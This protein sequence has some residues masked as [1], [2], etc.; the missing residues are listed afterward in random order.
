MRPEFIEIQNVGALPL[1]IG[2]YTFEGLTYTFPANTVI[3]PGAALLLA[4]SANPT[5]FAARYPGV[6][7]FG[8][9]GGNLSNGGE[10]VAILDLSGAIVTAVNYDDENG[11]PTSPDGGGYSLE[12]IDPRDDPDAPANWRASS[13]VNGT[14]GLPLVAPVQGNVVINEVAADNGGSVT[15]GGAFPDWVELYNRSGSPVNLANWSL[16]DDGSPRKFI[17]PG[18]NLAA[19]SYL[20]VWCDNATNASGLHTGFALGKNGENLFLYDAN[21]NRVDAISFGLQITDRTL[22]RVANEWRLTQPTPGTANVAA[23]L[24]SVTN[25]S[26]NEWLADAPPGSEDWVELLNRSTVAPVALRGLYLST[27]N[28]LF[29]IRNYSFLPPRGYVQLLADELPGVA[30]LGFKLPATGGAIALADETGVELQRIVYETQ[31]QSVSEGRWPDG[32]TSFSAFPGSASPGATNYLLAWSGPLL[33][34]VLARNE[35][36]ELAPWNNYADW[37][38]IYN[39]S[40]GM[41]N[42]AG[43]GLSKSSTAAARWVF[44]AGVTIP[45]FGY[46]RVWCDSSHAASSNSTAALNTGFSISGDSGDVYLFNAAGQVVD[47]VSY[48]FQLSD[49]SIGSSGGQWQLL[50]APTPGAANSV[51]TALGQVSSL[52]INEW[53]AAPLTGDDWFELYNTNALPVAIGGMFL[54][55]DPSSIGV[56]RS[57][58]APLSFIGGRKWLRWEAAGHPSNGRNH[59]GFSLDGAG[60]TLRLYD[61][62]TNLI[63]AVDFAIQDAGVS[64]GRL[65]DGATTVAT[66]P[67]TPTPGDANYL[68]ITTIVIN[69]ILTHTDPPLEDAIELF[70]PTVSSV[71]IGGW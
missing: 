43:L 23:P 17:L 31:T 2:G 3:A 8:Y 32:D 68:P 51:P 30:H 57:P 6:V 5:Q 49:V 25:L 65:P 50:A 60:E 27:S 41:A 28:A 16:S 56:V 18:T 54:T 1:N 26:I 29:Q 70:N 15:N 71:N 20:V 12:V 52:R 48:G 22:G 4:S 45:A 24:A 46:L 10:R 69:E 63:D 36:S 13:L 62:N 37:I 11:W 39:P 53:M 47:S 58:V 42:L 35:R 44:P 34:E 64:Q 9:F 61:A 33:N 59:V 7:V 21:T 67:T 40:N 14:P 55:D 19:G 38:E 66:F